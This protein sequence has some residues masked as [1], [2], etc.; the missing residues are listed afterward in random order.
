MYLLCDINDLF[1]NTIPTKA[2]CGTAFDLLTQQLKFV[3]HVLQM[4]NFLELV[5]VGM[6]VSGVNG[7]KV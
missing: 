7:S 1:W 6:C 2:S 4:P 5:F 3:L